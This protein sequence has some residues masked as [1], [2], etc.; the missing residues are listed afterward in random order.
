[1]I[2]I[3]VGSPLPDIYLRM[4]AN[5]D[6]VIGHEPISLENACD[7]EAYASQLGSDDKVRF[8]VTIPAEYQVDADFMVECP[9]VDVQDIDA[10]FNNATVKVP[11]AAFTKVLSYRN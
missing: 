4:I 8:I 7:A 1:M 9:L 2:D 6:W 11:V 10:H 5:L 3:H